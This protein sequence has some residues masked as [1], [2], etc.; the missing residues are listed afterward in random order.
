[1]GATL[2]RLSRRIHAAIDRHFYRGGVFHKTRNHSTLI[3]RIAAVPD[4]GRILNVGAGGYRLLPGAINVDPFRVRPGDVRAFGEAL[5]FADASID[6]V[7][8]SAVLEHVPD[9]H[10]IIEEI[11]RVLKVGGLVYIEVPFLQ[12]FHAAPDDYSRVTLPGLRRWLRHFEEIE[13]GACSGPGSAVGWILVEYVS[14][15]FRDRFLSR[16]ATY[17]MQVLV[18]PLK[19]LDPYLMRRPASVGLASGIYFYGTRPASSV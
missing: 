5:P 3:S 11:Y 13:A 8:C 6:C 19:Y 1:M 7:I 12:P 10:A 9:P 14:L 15:W 18:S 2:A 17:A 4:L 16:L